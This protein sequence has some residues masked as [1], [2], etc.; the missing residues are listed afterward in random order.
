MFEKDWNLLEKVFKLADGTRWPSESFGSVPQV[1]HDEPVLPP[2]LA[3]TRTA[4]VRGGRRTVV[5]RTEAGR[6]MKKFQH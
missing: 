3:R 4:E 6:K 5:D 1:A 2:T